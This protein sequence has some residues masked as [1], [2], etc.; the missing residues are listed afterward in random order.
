MLGIGKRILAPDVLRQFAG[1]G[2]RATGLIRAPAVLPGFSS[3]RPYSE[4]LRL[5]ERHFEGVVIDEGHPDT[6]PPPG[7][8]VLCAPYDFRRSIVD[9]AEEVARTVHDRFG[10]ASEIR[11]R[12][13]V[14]VVAHSM[15]GLVARWWLGPGGAG[16][17]CRALLTLGTPHRGAPK[18]LDW[19]VNGVRLKGIRFKRAT[20][21]LATWPSVYELLPRYPAVLDV[22]SGLARRPHEVF[23]PGLDRARA[24]AAL[25]LH[26]TIEGAWDANASPHRPEV[27]PFIGRF[28]ATPERAT[29]EGGRLVVEKRRAEWLDIDDWAGDGTVPYVSALPLEMN[30]SWGGRRMPAARHSALST[31]EVVVE[32]LDGPQ[33]A[34]T[35]GVRDPADDARPTLSLDAEEWYPAGE[36][37]PL[38]VTTRGADGTL[39]GPE[40]GMRVWACARPTGG[41]PEGEAELES[42]G[43]GHWRGEIGVLAPGTYELEISA[44]GRRGG[45]ARPLQEIVAVVEG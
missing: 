9:A 38:E 16:P 45:E 17:L 5:L 43:D 6:P 14:V 22:A 3:L 37:L 19:L 42:C 10:P 29:L 33:G 21:V 26:E 32:A 35:A 11:N 39:E 28:Q 36:S 12:G 34:P 4:L 8:N 30:R 24:R 44:P 7:A 1:D 18:A 2:I 15:G 31:L 23:V 20:E 25:D 27:V 41:G 13:G 40:E